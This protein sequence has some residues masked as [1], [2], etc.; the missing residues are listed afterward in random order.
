MALK[1]QAERT[2]A[3]AFA[4]TD[5]TPADGDVAARGFG[6]PTTII[7]LLA[8]AAFFWWNM[9]RRRQFE[10]RMREQRRAETVVQAEQSAMNVAHIMRSA[11]SRAEAAAAASE[12]LA[13]AASVYPPA[14]STPQPDESLDRAKAADLADRAAAEEAERAAFLAEQ[15]S[16]GSLKVAGANVAAAQARADTADVPELSET[17]SEADTAAAA[18]EGSEVRLEDAEV[19]A[20]ATANESQIPVH[21]GVIVAPESQTPEDAL[22]QGLRE[23]DE[24]ADVPFGA[25]AGD[26]TAVCA[27]G[28]PIKGNSSSKIY[29]EPN[30]TSYPQTIAEFCFAT[31]EA[32]EI[33]GY[34]RSK[35]HEQRGPK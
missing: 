26:G 20:E 29:H 3:S 15:A 22:R 27:E 33:A 13:S 16:R 6:S 8:A 24:E 7:L 10:D 2:V 25:V 18:M 9:R 31:A 5:E 4:Q 17:L 21:P 11:P 32:A 34:R 28:Y 1:P 30:Q 12:G 35:A 23:L 14:A 19:V